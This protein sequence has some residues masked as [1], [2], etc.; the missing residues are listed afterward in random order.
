MGLPFVVGHVAVSLDGATTGF[1]VDIGRYYSLIQ[2]WDEDMTLAGADTILAQEAALDEAP[3]PGP[4]EG[5]PILAVV[6]SK[7]R[8][9]S[10]DKLRRCGYWADVVALR[11][12]DHPDG[13]VAE[14][15]TQGT[16]VDLRL[17]LRHL[18]D[19]RA[20]RVVRVDSGG[21][22]L[23]AL[24]SKGLVDELSL[25]VHPLLTG[26]TQAQRWFGRDEGRTQ[27]LSLLAAERLE[28]GLLWLRYEIPSNQSKV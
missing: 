6:D 25:L 18:T 5:A 21:A 1:D 26:Q 11:I 24:L 16:R 3:M 10:W 7:R 2:T 12:D 13:E 9:T 27:E 23:G 17:A 19:E 14:I 8:V 20:A 22:L 4:R 28:S 15:V